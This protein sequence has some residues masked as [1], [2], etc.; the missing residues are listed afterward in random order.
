ML[1]SV[2][3]SICCHVASFSAQ[4]LLDSEKMVTPM[5]ISTASAYSHV[6]YRVPFSNVPI[7]ITGMT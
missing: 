2:N 1:R 6:E 4:L 3:P 7:S 5:V